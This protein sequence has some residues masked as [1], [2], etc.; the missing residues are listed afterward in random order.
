MVNF[1]LQIKPELLNQSM[2]LVALNENK[3]EVARELNYVYENTLS[4]NSS[5][6]ALINLLNVTSR[7]SMEQSIH[8][9]AQNIF[10][11]LFQSSPDGILLIEK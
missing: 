11:K 6:N 4:A 9:E 7:E 5:T 10:E 8:I 3:I 1:L 2:T